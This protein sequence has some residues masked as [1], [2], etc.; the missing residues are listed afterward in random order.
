[1]KRTIMVVDDDPD[2]REI[3]T[4]VLKKASS[5]E[6]LTV[7]SGEAALTLLRG[8]EE[9]PAVM[10][11]DLKMPGMNGIDALRLIRSDGR[12]KDLP[13]VIVTNSTLESDRIAALN[14]GADGFIHKAFDI[15]Q[16]QNA[17][18]SC[19]ACWLSK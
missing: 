3:T 19:L 16:Y 18:Q 11:I 10:L 17:L 9:L 7:S 2:D 1:M 6:C 13:V 14:A 8:R 15:E 5:A 4:R 12:L